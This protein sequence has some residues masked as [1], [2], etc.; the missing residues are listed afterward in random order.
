MVRSIKNAFAPVNRIP[1]EILSLIPDY[2]EA[3]DELIKL[4]HVC[5]HWRTT[6]ISR[7]SLWTSLDCMNLDQ[8]ST[9]I[10]RSGVAPLKIFLTAHRGTYYRDDAL[11]LTLPLFDR[12]EALVFA[13]FSDDILKLIGQPSP[14][15]PLLERLDIEIS[16]A[17][18]VVFNSRLL[19]GNLSLCELRLSRV[20]T[21]LP[22][23]NLSNL[24]TFHFR[25]VPSNT[26]TVTQLLDFFEDVPL[27]REIK[28]N[29]SLPES[30]NAPAK[31]VVYLPHLRILGISAQLAPLILI[32]LNHL[33]IPI[34]ALLRLEFRF[35]RGESPIPDYSSIPFDNLS[36]IS[37]I[38]SVNLDFSSGIAMRLK[39]P[40]GGLYIFGT[41]ADLAP[42]PHSL[43]EQ[44]LQSLGCLPI[45]TIERLSITQYRTVSHWKIEG[46]GA[47]QTALHLDGP[48]QTL[49]LMNNLRTL[50]LTDCPDVS[51]TTTLTPSENASSA[52]VCPGLKEYVLYIGKEGRPRIE[53]LL[54]M[55]KERASMGARLSAIVFNCPPQLFPEKAPALESYVS[56]VE[57]NSGD[58]TPR[59]RW[60]TILGEA[61]EVGYDSDW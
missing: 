12:L 46:S 57:Y 26:I 15:A 36:N 17:R 18:Y 16:D 41:W 61:D 4:T 39:G 23:R 28:L 7:A 6:F 24:T 14:P 9:Y 54:K 47:H 20:V 1:P 56:H 59:P 49:L 42:I 5:H 55:A 22:W 51:F 2:C 35:G 29:K 48:Y 8:T 44:T 11:L 30:S 50:T 37:H 13:G 58:T 19:D 32:L 10:Q 43:G 45:S 3:N 25:G 27:L 21:S 38:T 52:V 33:H 53:Y 60:D 40:S 34:G 31:R